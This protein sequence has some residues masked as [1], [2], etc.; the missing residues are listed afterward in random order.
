MLA[1]WGPLNLPGASIASVVTD[2][3]GNTYLGG[4]FRGEDVDFDPLGQ[5]WYCDTQYNA[6]AGR[7]VSDAFVARYRSDG[8]LAWIREFE[9]TLPEAGMAW[10]TGAASIDVKADGSAVYLA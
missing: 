9:S 3:A 6:L 2:S 1:T 4:D 7:Y 8:T 10:D 5:H